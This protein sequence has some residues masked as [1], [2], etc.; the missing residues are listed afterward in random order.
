MDE[1]DKE[2]L[3]KRGPKHGITQEGKDMRDEMIADF[4]IEHEIM[5]NRS[6][7]KL[8]NAKDKKVSNS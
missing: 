6:K 2:T 5:W 7:N 1:D 8:S 4:V 3:K